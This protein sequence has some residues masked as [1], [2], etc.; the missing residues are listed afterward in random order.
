[1]T[2]DVEQAGQQ[3]QQQGSYDYTR[4]VEDYCAQVRNQ[5][6]D[7]FEAAYKNTLLRLDFSVGSRVLDVGG[8]AGQLVTLLARRGCN[9]T[10]LDVSEA[11][12]TFAKEICAARL[13]G[14]E[15]K[16]I[17][18]IMGDLSSFPARASLMAEL[19]TG[20]DVIILRQVWEHLTPEQCDAT[21]NN[22]RTLLAKTGYI[23]VE[24]EPNAPLAEFLRWVK[25]TFLRVHGGYRE[26]G[27]HINEQ[28][29]RSL[30]KAL[31]RYEWADS[32]VRPYLSDHWL[33]REGL[34][35][36]GNKKQKVVLP[37][38]YV[39][40]ATLNFA[41]RIPILTPFLCYGSAGRL[42]LRKP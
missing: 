21:I 17:R 10:L 14:E 22:C 11:G 5:S 16:R 40:S 32:H 2:T 1:V 33:Y 30:R 42:T 4:Y 18:F 39:I 6:L 28:S 7:D 27:L 9:A 38:I 13:G 35:A 29:Y 12:V 34:L 19:G 25:R 31:A 23:Y 37:L 15:A 24:T 20:Y 26:E 8:G 3:T 41:A 36:L